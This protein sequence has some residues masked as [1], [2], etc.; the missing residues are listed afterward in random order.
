[1]TVDS[2]ADLRETL[3]ISFDAGKLWISEEAG[4]FQR[5]SK[6][7]FRLFPRFT[8]DHRSFRSASSRRYSSCSTDPNSARKRKEHDTK[9]VFLEKYAVFTGISDATYSVSLPNAM[10]YSHFCLSRRMVD[11]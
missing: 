3:K 5:F 8:S 4:S 1:M 7:T 9:V 11:L 10:P 2:A 6:A